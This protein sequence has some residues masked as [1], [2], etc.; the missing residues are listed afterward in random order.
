MWANKTPAGSENILNILLKNFKLEES[1]IE[2]KEKEETVKKLN[3][4]NLAPDA[5]Q[6]MRQKSKLK[7]RQ[8]AFKKTHNADK[9]RR[10]REEKTI[11][12]RKSKKEERLEKLRMPP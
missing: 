10:E 8:N 3:P 11:Q 5:K 12:I 7:M 4:Q 6:K 1:K 9:Q 2:S